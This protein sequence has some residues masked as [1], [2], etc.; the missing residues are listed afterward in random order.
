M[1]VFQGAMAAGSAAWGALANK[2]GI[3]AA[4]LWAGVGTMASTLTGLL[5][6]LPDATVD[7]TPWIH[8]RLPTIVDQDP[9]AADAGP[10]MVMI[11]YSVDQ[12]KAAGF[13][14]AIYKYERIRRRDGAYQWGVFC[15][16]EDPNRYLEV[17]LV[18][19][20]AE[21]LSAPSARIELWRRNWKAA[22]AENRQCAILWPQRSRWFRWHTE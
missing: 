13:T 19:S 15:D 16:L 21:H 1:L 10:V 3:H 5:L 6:K 4:L 14:T 9:T 11:E 17:F 18:D 22:F 2:T 8:W 7:L 12:E 20:W